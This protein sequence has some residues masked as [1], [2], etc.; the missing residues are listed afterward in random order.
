MDHYSIDQQLKRFPRVTLP[1][2]KLNI[3]AI[4]W[5]PEGT[6]IASGGKDKTLNLHR[7][8]ET[9]IV[10]DHQFSNNGHTSDIDQLCWN[11]ENPNLLA[12]ASLDR[13]VKIWDVRYIDPLSSIKLKNENMSVSWSQTGS[14]IAVADK[15]D[16]VS[17]I[18]TRGGFKVFKD[19]K[20]QFEVGDISW[21]KEGDL[22]YVATGDG[23][24]HILNFPDL[25]TISVIDAFA[26][27]CVCM[28]FD[29][30]GKYFA[31]GSNDAISSVWDTE[32]SAC[33]QAIDRLEW[34][35]KTVGFSYD[36]K[37]IASGSDDSF[38]DIA[39]IY[40]GEQV[41]SI[42]VNDPTL[43]L[44]FHPKDYILAYA[45][46]EH[47]YRDYGTIRIV[48]FPENRRRMYA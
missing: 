15:A 45:L 41:V 18:D 40:T 36:S 30:T 31:V 34:P 24:I 32:N 46:N 25:Q 38:I 47:E 37:Y 1:S 26:S 6:L 29:Q 22:F 8:K 23:N 20:F 3:H 5:S 12:T 16:V 19:Q 28:R 44:D 43:T 35:V 10:V 14:T 13:H 11:P 2:H 27:P 9:E 48:G 7:V 42:E 17:F 33:I 21:C 39:D 4:R